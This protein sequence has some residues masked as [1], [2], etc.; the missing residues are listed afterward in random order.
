MGRLMFFNNN[1]GKLMSENRREYFRV[2]FE[3]TI[4]GQIIMQG[5]DSMYISIDNLSVKGL[6]F[7]SS[8]EIPLHAKVECRFEIL[9]S[10]F[11]LIG[12]IIRKS[13]NTDDI[14]YGID[15]VVDKEK[16]SHLFK[17]L[18]TYQIRQRKGNYFD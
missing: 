6:G 10:P 3:R 14:T 5:G 12:S 1:G 11:E 8:I 7:S 18:N 15:F 13:R 17:Q 9:D 2:N 16:S 4:A